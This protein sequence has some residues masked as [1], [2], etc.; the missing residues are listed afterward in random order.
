MRKLI[1]GRRSGALLA[2]CLAY[3]LAIE[4]LIASVGLGMS[5][6][7][8]SGNDGFALC[9]HAPD[10]R[11]TAPDDRRLPNPAPQC[12]FCFV[13]AQ[14]SCDVAAMGGAP[15]QH[16]YAGLPLAGRLAGGAGTAFVSQFRRT[17]GAPRGPPV[18]SI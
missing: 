3:A 7:A 11:T 10:S 9:V 8:A 2:L 14:S 13:A 6:T 5:A 1:Q 15:P 17:V 4:S 16:A 18:F 12:P